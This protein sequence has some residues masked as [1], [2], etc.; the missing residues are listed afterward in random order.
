MPKPPSCRTRVIAIRSLDPVVL[1]VDLAMLEPPEIAFEAGQWVAIPLGEKIVRPYSMASPP[2]ERRT[3]R[4][5]VDVKPGGVGSRYF[6]ELKAGDEVAFQPPLG[7]L[8]L[9]RDSTAPVLLVAEEIGI[10]PFRSILLAQAEQGFPRLMTLYFTA[11]ARAYLTYHDELGRLAA[12]HARFHY[13]PLLSAPDPGWPGEVGSVLAVLEREAGDLR[14]H[15]ALLCGG[16]DLVKA[17][18]ELCLARGL[19]RKRIRYEKFW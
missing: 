16:G 18:R 6:R 9:G 2:S 13:R 14:G 15:E 10:V 11:P 7:T 5:C 8:T 17:A 19:E 12:D 1:E 4:L 3:I